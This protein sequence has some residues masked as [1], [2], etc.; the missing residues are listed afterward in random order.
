MPCI[1]RL[2][3]LFLPPQKKCW[4]RRTNSKKSRLDDFP[5][6]SRFLTGN[7]MIFPVSHG[8]LKTGKNAM[9]SQEQSCFLYKKTNQ[10]LSLSRFRKRANLD[11]WNFSNARQWSFLRKIDYIDIVWTFCDSI[12]FL[13]K[14]ISFISFQVFFFKKCHIGTIIMKQ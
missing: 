9:P 2:I 13:I 14:Y 12:I 7:Y 5:K 3:L 11:Y 8:K 6:F 1:V 10:I 4:K